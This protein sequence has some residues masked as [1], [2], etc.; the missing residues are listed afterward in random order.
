M[1]KSTL[2]IHLYQEQYSYPGFFEKSVRNPLFL[3]LSSLTTQKASFRDAESYGQHTAKALQAMQESR[4]PSSSHMIQERQQFAQ[5]V[6]R[7][8]I[9]VI[10]FT[11]PWTY[12]AHVKTSSEYRGRLS[13]VQKNWEAYIERLVREYS[14]FLLIVSQPILSKDL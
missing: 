7:F 10:F 9:N 5:S 3:I 8:I 12:L 2:T 13:G 14:D 1:I 6:I 4:A 11:I